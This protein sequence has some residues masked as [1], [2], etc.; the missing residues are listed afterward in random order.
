MTE[1]D[2]SDLPNGLTIYK[3]S[4]RVRDRVNRRQYS[5]AIGRV[6]EMTQEEAIS[7]MP[8][9]LREFRERHTEKDNYIEPSGDDWEW[10]DRINEFKSRG[11]NWLHKMYKKAQQRDKEKNRDFDLTWVELKQIAINSKGC[12]AVTGIRFSSDNPSNS[13]VA[14]FKPSLDRIDSSKGYSRENCRLIC[15]AANLALM[16]FGEE[17]FG[18]IAIG[19]AAKAFQNLSEKF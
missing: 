4:W 6:S 7:L 13:R 19:Y 9:T 17:V 18:M 11:G 16:D 14:P 12:C 1:I 8:E 2:N 10:D 15:A 3:G 5:K